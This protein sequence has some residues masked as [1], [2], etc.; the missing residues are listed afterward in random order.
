MRSIRGKNTGPEM[1]V[2]HLTYSMG[3]RYRLYRTDLPGR[4][5][6]VFLGRRKAIFVHGCFWHRHGCKLT[7]PLPLANRRYWRRKF[8]RNLARD[9]EQEK[10]LRRAGWRV[11]V[12]WECETRDLEK[13]RARLR[14]F[15]G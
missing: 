3:Y 15:L 7:R 9:A 8:A 14:K 6:L 10:A 12:V 1:A 11:L 4:P 5:D 2:R 13:L